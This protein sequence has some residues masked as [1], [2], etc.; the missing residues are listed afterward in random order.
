MRKLSLLTLLTFLF[1]NLLI[2]QI[3]FNSENIIV[4]KPD[5]EKNTFEQDTTAN[6]VIL[7]EF[8]NA[9]I[10]KRTFELVFEYKKK[11]KILNREG[12]KHS[13][14][15][16]RLYNSDRN[17]E[18]I[19]NIKGSTTNLVNGQIK[20]TNLE[21]SQ[22]FEDKIDENNTYIKF[23]LPDI[24]EGSV[25][26]YTYELRTPFIYKYQPWYFQEDLP[27]LYSEYITSIPANYD[28][29]IK[30]VG[31]LELKT[32]D[33][34]LDKYCIKVSNGGSAHCTV[35][36][37]VMTNI[38]AFREESYMRAASNYI[39]RIEYELK[40]IN[41]FDG[42]VENITKSWETA[43][44]ELKTNQNF[45]KQLKKESLV[46]KLI[47][48][49]EILKQNSTLDK[50]KLIYDFVKNN[51][52]WNNKHR[53]FKDI[54]IKDVIDDKSGN[55]AEINLL[56]YNLLKSN[57]LK[58]NPVLLSTRDHGLVTKLFPV[59]SEF[60]YLI[61][62]LEI[63]GKSYF[64]DATDKDLVFGQIPF[65][66]LN[67]YGREIDFNNG[68][69][70]ID[71][72]PQTKSSIIQKS[73]ITIND[74]YTFNAT[75]NITSLGF[76]ALDIKKEFNKNNQKFIDYY[77]QAFPDFTFD[78]IDVLIDEDTL[79]V[80]EIITFSGPVNTIGNKVFFDPFIFKN[81]T[82]NPLKL[83]ERSYPVDFGYKDMYTNRIKIFFSDNFVVNDIS[84]ENTKQLPQ[85]SALS[86][87]K[88]KKESGIVEFYFKA[89]FYE[90]SY[91]HFYYKELKS[92]FDNLVDLQS[93]S[94]LVLEKKG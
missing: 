27:K 91:H 70:W 66:C 8:G 22:I 19:N 60:N 38:P 50:A 4:T 53:I 80:N 21:P 58:V 46:K 78:N 45:G 28:Y 48:E 31:D 74:D 32:H 55:T 84:K 69:K 85:S 40:T 75:I 76:K 42:V 5:L 71:L 35:A 36:K 20:R 39:S 41:R 62:K 44:K 73:E 2:A 56:L 94:I 81:F 63:E 23:T 52:T 25:I 37:Y 18:K 86:I 12:F 54:S 33:M 13:N 89:N 10:D 6:A 88:S 16:L 59:I 29:H 30:L 72:E 57:D 47:P 83:Q 92:F 11:V 15:S 34:T 79:K 14:I 68:S 49:E 87:F 26:T 67:D 17:K 65:K 77:T 64:L 7:Y 90:K 82:E 1:T 51:Y 9:Y 24:K 43:D 61:L 93:N 3:Q